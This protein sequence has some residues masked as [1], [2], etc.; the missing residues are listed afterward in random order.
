MEC[1]TEIDVRGNFIQSG[2]H[3]LLHI[4]VTM[5]S[6]LPLQTCI[7]GRNPWA[8][9]TLIST[10]SFKI[11]LQLQSHIKIFAKNPG[12]N[13]GLIFPLLRQN[14]SAFRIPIQHFQQKS[15]SKPYSNINNFVKN[16]VATAIAYPD[17]RSKSW[18]KWRPDLSISLAN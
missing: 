14:L 9:H 5:H 15:S 18:S 4:E 1:S 6:M 12:A 8:S 13:E 17:F 2:V 11:L 7:F 16:L 3:S 10:I